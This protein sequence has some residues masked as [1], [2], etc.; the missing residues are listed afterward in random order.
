M[1]RRATEASIFVLIAA[2]AARAWLVEGLI[3][4]VRVSSGSMAESILGP[5]VP[6]RCA[7]CGFEFACDATE[8]PEPFR[9]VCPQCGFTN[10][11][12]EHFMRRSGDRLILDKL[13]FALRAP[14]RW[15]VVVYRCPPRPT[16][17]CVKRVVGL[18]GETVAIRDGDVFVDGRPA[19]KSLEEL[20]KLAVPVF[21][22]R[23]KSR[24][25]PQMPPCWRPLSV[26]SAW[27]ETESGYKFGGAGTEDEHNGNHRA[28]KDWL[29]YCH[30]VRDADGVFNEAAVTDNYGFNQALS[31]RLNHVRD[32]LLIA[33]VAAHGDGVMSLMATYAGR[34]FMIDV[35]P[36]GGLGRFYRDGKALKEFH[37]PQNLFN[38][39]VT[40]RLALVDYRILLEIDGR[41][42]VE[43]DIEPPPNESRG[44]AMHSLPSSAARPLGIGAAG[45]S[46]ELTNVKLLR[47]VFYTDFAPGQSTRAEAWKLGPDE[48]FV[49]GD[50]SPISRDSRLGRSEFVPA[51]AILGKPLVW[52]RGPR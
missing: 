48:Y 7:D 14:R 37:I 31:R 42:V 46:V 11:S 5:H 12:P 33:D 19:H 34:D 18:P 43:Y 9:A 22:S 4:P 28:T 45:L 51:H 36:S 20:A 3:T 49:L 21:D 44:A 23:V 25:S 13:A 40:L 52:R 50:N 24:N 16:E 10:N 29:W 6:V 8:L 17:Y 30:A 38:E 35:V 41:A 32:L 39:R 1:L 27:M 47:D 15:E 26:S 2:I